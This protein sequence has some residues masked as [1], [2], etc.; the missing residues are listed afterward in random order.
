M[1]INETV[2]GLTKPFYNRFLFTFCALLIAHSAYAYEKSGFFIGLQ[3]SKTQY[4]VVEKMNYAHSA[5]LA[6]SQTVGSLGDITCTTSDRGGIAGVFNGKK[7]KCVPSST[8][9]KIDGNLEVDLFID[10][11][12]TLFNNY[13][14]TYGGILGYKHFF[15]EEMTYEEFSNFTLPLYRMGFRIY[16][17]YDLGTIAKNYKNTSFNL[18]FDALYNFFPHYQK[19][20]LGAFVGFSLG[21]TSY[22]L[23]FYKVKGIDH[24]INAGLRLT[25]FENFNIELFSRIGLGKLKYSEEKD[26]FIDGKG[27]S[28]YVDVEACQVY[29]SQLWNGNPPFNIGVSSQPGSY[30]KYE[31]KETTSQAP[32]IN[33]KD[34]CTKIGGD[35][36]QGVCYVTTTTQIPSQMCIKITDVTQASSSVK[37]NSAV[38]THFAQELE[39][40]LQI[41]IRFTY[42]F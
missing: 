8:N 19:W 7:T 36:K 42:T 32:N 24:A 15:A 16:L 25:V 23:G 22:D 6:N 26:Y 34:D 11:I 10:S 31:S 28:N 37:L 39:K 1:K 41:G 12:T 5:A 27:G 35:F 3:G 17:V 21:Y 29:N 18:N 13:A 14:M 20:D 9:I 40:P 2:K 4:K 33:T 30:I 38:I